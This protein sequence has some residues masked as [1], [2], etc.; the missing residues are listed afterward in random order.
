MKG[1]TSNFYYALLP[2][3]NNIIIPMVR[4]SFER[5]GFRLNSSDFRGAVTV[6]PTPGLERIAVPELPFDDV[7]RYPERSRPEQLQQSE[8]RRRQRLSRPTEFA[9][10]LI[11]YV[12]ATIG[13]CL[14]CGH[15]EYEDTSHEEE[16]SNDEKQFP[17]QITLSFLCKRTMA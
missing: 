7:F 8:L 15:E 10:N 2:F 9:I 14:L 6:D 16:A 17:D 11:A 12:D 1:E 5:A 4:G 13:K 3:Y